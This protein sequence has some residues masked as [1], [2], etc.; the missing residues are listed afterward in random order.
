MRFLL[1]S[2][3]FV[4]AKCA[5]EILRDETRAALIDPANDVFVSVATA[6]ELWIKHAKKPIAEI[7]SVLD[8]GATGFLDAARASSMALLSITLDHAAAA[9]AL[10]PLHRDPFDR[11]L[12]GQAIAEGLTM[13]T[14]DPIFKRYK[15]L[16]IL[17]G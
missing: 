1:D 2:H 12:I 7:A 5:P 13:V 11:L 14:S 17:E 10:P 9:S 3:I 6:W 8:R 16:R 4:W 15:G